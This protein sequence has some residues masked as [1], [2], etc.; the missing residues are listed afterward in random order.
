MAQITLVEAVNLALARAMAKAPAERFQ[1][2]D[3]FIMALE[4]AKSQPLR[5]ETAP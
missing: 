2:Y 4:A 3:E 5:Q 1:S